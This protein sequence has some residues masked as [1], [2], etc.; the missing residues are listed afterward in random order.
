MIGLYLNQKATWK[1]VVGRNQYG[2]PKTESQEISVRWEAKRRMV[3]DKEGH[4]IVSEARVFCVEQVLAG[5]FLEHD[6]RTWPVIAVSGI[7]GLAG[8]ESHREVYV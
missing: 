1:S 8:D 4:E 2:E 6:G 5:D 7:P 3:R